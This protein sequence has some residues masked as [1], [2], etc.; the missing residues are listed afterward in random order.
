MK[1][2]LKYGIASYSGT[3][4]EITFASYKNGAV[5]I[6]RKYVKPTLTENNSRMGDIAKNISLIYGGCSEE[7]KS[8]L[9]TYASIYGKEETP[10]NSLSPNSYGL[11]VKMMFNFS[12]I[13]GGGVD[14]TSITLNDIQSLFVELTTIATAVDAGYLPKVSGY[15]LLDSSM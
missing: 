8:D 2:K 3:I 14:L 10:R 5:C 1:T 9:R 6:A 13:N 12:D 11:F 7:F 4:D 15:E